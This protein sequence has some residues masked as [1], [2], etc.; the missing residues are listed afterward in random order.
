MIFRKDEEP[1]EEQIKVTIGCDKAH[2]SVVL[3]SSFLSCGKTQSS[4]VDE[5]AGEGIY[6]N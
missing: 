4:P 5:T 2:L 1:L 3:T 6:G